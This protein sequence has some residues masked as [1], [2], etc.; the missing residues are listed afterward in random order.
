MHLR[1]ESGQGWEDKC[2]EQV[3]NGRKDTDEMLKRNQRQSQLVDKRDTGRAAKLILCCRFVWVHPCFSHCSGWWL[4]AWYQAY[5]GQQRIRSSL[6]SPSFLNRPG[7]CQIFTLKRNWTPQPDL[8]WLYCFA[9]LT[10]FSV[11]SCSLCFLFSLQFSVNRMLI[12][13]FQ[14]R[15]YSIAPYPSAVFCVSAMQDPSLQH[16][17][18]SPSTMHLYSRHEILDVVV[19]YSAI[20]RLG[21]SS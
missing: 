11:T 17:G 13:I 19:R 3:R 6:C 1:S 2:R 12:F 4:W 18:A 10:F 14:R 16:V 8:W 15:Y 21:L 9:Y 5:S 7:G 20:I